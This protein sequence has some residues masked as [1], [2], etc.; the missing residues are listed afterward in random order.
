MLKHSRAQK[1][2]SIQMATD[3]HQV[4]LKPFQKCIVQATPYEQRQAIRSVSQYAYKTY[5]VYVSG[6][7]AGSYFFNYTKKSLETQMCVFH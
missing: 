5:T 7:R 3:Y 2:E 6:S 1:L 4:L